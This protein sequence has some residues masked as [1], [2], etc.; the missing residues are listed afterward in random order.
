M[1]HIAPGTGGVI[2][3]VGLFSS[4]WL[5]CYKLA[6][7]DSFTFEPRGEGSFESRL[8]NYTKAAETLIGLAS[9]SVVLLAGS[10]ILKGGAR[11]PWFFASPLLLLGLSVVF[12]VFFIA[13]LTFFYEGYLNF[14]KSY[15][16]VKYSLIQALGFS[17][18]MSFALAYIWLVLE[19]TA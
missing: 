2:V 15:T 12:A 8:A 11:L 14:P 4:A 16:R 13:L 7:Y 10:S 17:S 1:Q 6:N 5:T 18:L 3:G 19:L 9:G